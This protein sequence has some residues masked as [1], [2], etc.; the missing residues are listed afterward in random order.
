MLGDGPYTKQ[1][2]Q[3]FMGH[4]VGFPGLEIS[5]LLNL[6]NSWTYQHHLAVAERNPV[7]NPL[8]TI[9]RVFGIFSSNF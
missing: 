6:P 4:K 3:D 1:T 8:L 9:D 2:N 7:P 5:N